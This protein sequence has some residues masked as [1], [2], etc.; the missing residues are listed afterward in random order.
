MPGPGTQGSTA[1]H[2][3]VVRTLSSKRD[4]SMICIGSVLVVMYRVGLPVGCQLHMRVRSE[5]QQAICP[6]TAP[7]QWRAQ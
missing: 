4:I 3:P 2:L 5:H 6:G 1:H 7:Q